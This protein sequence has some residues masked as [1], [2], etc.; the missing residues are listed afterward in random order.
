MQRRELLAELSGIAIARV[1]MYG[2]NQ[3]ARS[4][5]AST[6]AGWKKYHGN[7]V[8][9]G[10][11]G[12]VFDVAVLQE[13][14]R[15]LLWGSWRPK[16]SLALF[17]SSDGIH[18]SEPVIVLGPNPETSW[19]ENINRPVVVKR[20][21]LY[22]L[23]YTGQ[24]NGKSFIGYATS[25][26]GLNFVRQSKTP[27][28]APE[29]PWEKTSVMCPDVLWDPSLGKYRMW[30]SGGDQY[31]PD[32]IGYATSGDGLHWT[33]HNPNPI[34][35]P[36][37]SIAWEQYKVTACQVVQH[38]GAFYMFYIG[39]RDIDHAQIGVAQ[40]VNGISGWRR[41]PAN[42]IIRAEPG[43]WDGDAC[44]KPFAI[45]DGDRWLLWYNGRHKTLEQIGLAV[46]K[47]E[48]LGFE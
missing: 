40:S 10:Q 14:Q 25:P 11:Y 6:S 15:F 26:N 39:F 38:S 44:Y 4:T 18:W 31:E 21:G 5:K 37:R 33:R 24:A 35:T 9:G 41:H 30:Y 45:L 43:N 22:H 23:W 17:G 16:K 13:S 20:D 3:E 36:D 19:E 29:Q 8:I 42:P 34:F 46:H 47:G 32:A 48:S 1:T 27:V 7:P 2:D 12:T 28:L